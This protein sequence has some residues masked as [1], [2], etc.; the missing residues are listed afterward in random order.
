MSGTRTLSSARLLGGVFSLLLLSSCCEDELQ[1]EPVRIY[2]YGIPTALAVTPDGR[3]FLSG[4]PSRAVLR[5]I[6]S[7]KVLRVFEVGW[8]TRITRWPLTNPVKSVTVLALSPDGTWLVTVDTDQTVH[9]W[10]IPTGEGPMTLEGAAIP[11]V[12]AVAFSGDSRVIARGSAD[13][14]VRLW[15]VPSGR[16]IAAWIAHTNEV[17]CLT[18]VHDGTRL[19][20]GSGGDRVARLWNVARA[21]RLQSFAAGEL[22]QAVAFAPDEA[23]LIVAS[24]FWDESKRVWVGLVRW[25]D[26][27]TAELLRALQNRPGELNTLDLSRDGS[28]LVTAHSDGVARLWEVASGQLVGKL[29]H[30]AGVDS[31]LFTPDGRGVLTRTGREAPGVWSWDVSGMELV[32]RFEGYSSEITSVALSPDGSRVIT[33]SRNPGAVWLWDTATGDLLHSLEQTHEVRSIAL[34]ADGARL[35]VGGSQPSGTTNQPAGLLSLYDLTTGQ[36][37]R[38]VDEDLPIHAVA[39]SSD[40]SQ[41]LVGCGSDD[42]WDGYARLRSAET[43]AVLQTFTNEWLRPVTSVVFSPDDTEVLTC[44]ASWSYSEVALWDLATGSLIRTFH[45]PELDEAGSAV[46]TPDGAQV[47]I[48]AVHLYFFDRAT[49]QLV[50]MIPTDINQTFAAPASAIY[51]PTGKQLL[52]T[53]TYYYMSQQPVLECTELLDLETGHAACALPWGGKPGIFSRDGERVLTGGT[54]GVAALWETRDT[55]ALLTIRSDGDGIRV[56]WDM[57]ILQHAPTLQGPWTDLPATSPFAVSPIHEQGYFR[58][59]L[60]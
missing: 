23:E 1:K 7:G 31:A 9:L 58:V 45:V 27:T 43:G 12:T 3:N 2:G 52:L 33:G 18:L 29:Q 39:F 16:D 57:G 49:G 14:S 51:S 4:G 8:N 25:F 6:E 54:A 21:E 10:N 11:T 55:L 13:G 44:S 17:A 42:Q 56:N 48:T 40:D 20:T 38:V 59:R 5:D 32:H 24:R 15:D 41:C 60:E 19:L 50:K 47:L 22:V 36:R 37:V 46:F 26:P 30:P 53:S 28:R 34:S 35:L